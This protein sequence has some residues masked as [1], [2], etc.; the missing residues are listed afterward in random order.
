MDNKDD[1]SRH[2]ICPQIQSN[3]TSKHSRILHRNQSLIMLF[4]YCYLYSNSKNYLTSF[5]QNS[6]ES[7][8]SSHH[9]TA[10]EVKDSDFFQVFYPVFPFTPIPAILYPEKTLVLAR[11][12]HC[13]TLATITR[14]NQTYSSHILNHNRKATGRYSTRIRFLYTIVPL[15]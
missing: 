11:A 13:E 3:Q 8:D 6:S 5:H 15:Y 1:G 7:C 2:F 12:T 10:T 4:S 9:I 14:Q